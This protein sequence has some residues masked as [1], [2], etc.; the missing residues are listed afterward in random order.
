MFYLRVSFQACA[1]ILTGGSLIVSF[2][3]LKQSHH[4]FRVSVRITVT[5]TLIFWVQFMMAKETLLKI[6]CGNNGAME[7]ERVLDLSYGLTELSDLDQI[8]S[9]SDIF[10][11]VQHSDSKEIIVKSDVKLCNNSECDGAVC[12]DLH[13]CKYELMTGHCNR[14][15][16]ICT[17]QLCEWRDIR[18]QTVNVSYFFSF[19]YSAEHV[20]SSTEG[21]CSSHV[22]TGEF[23]CCLCF[24]RRVC[25]FGH[26]LMSEH[27][28]RILRDHQISALSR[29]E[30]CVMLLQ[31]DSNLLPPVSLTITSHPCICNDITNTAQTVVIPWYSL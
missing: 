9:K 28:I 29:E 31:S 23:V 13:L 14:C 30:L 22:I 2:V 4:W 17:S 24:I 11:V 19:S 27:N 5:R 7:Y 8:I 21:P 20:F 6:L 12:G 25:V 15:V 26:D 1:Y 3:F 18:S 16:Y 10:T